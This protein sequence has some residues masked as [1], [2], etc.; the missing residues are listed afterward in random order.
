MAEGGGT[1]RPVSSPFWPESVK[2]QPTEVES[3][4]VIERRRDEAV[5]NPGRLDHSW[6]K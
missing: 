2:S 5:V 3:P 4:P 6:N 1:C